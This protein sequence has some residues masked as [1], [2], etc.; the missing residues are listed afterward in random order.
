[1]DAGVEARLQAGDVTFD[2][3]DAELLR[4]IADHESVS[5]AAQALGR[6][7][8]RALG[9]LTDLEKAFGPLVER[10][11]GG[12]GGGGSH[13][14]PEARTLL[15][16]FDRLRATLSGT[17]RVVETVLRGTVVERE[18]ELGVVETDAGTVRSRLVDG[19]AENGAETTGDDG[20]GRRTRLDA[21]SR[22]QVSVRADMVTLHDPADAPGGGAT[23]ARNRFSGAVSRVEPGTA[24]ARVVVEVGA[25]NPL[26][27]LVTGESRDRLGLEPGVD[28]VAS[29]KATATR[30]TGTER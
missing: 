14:T 16:R 20:T 18:G 23:S 1:M 19:V 10:Q 2:A 26:V 11:R 4:A 7:R 5:G 27:A 9:R 25:T 29:F 22:V 24:V 6:S 8:A 3:T 12:A 17:A 30:A 28:V 15:A 21:G 13:L